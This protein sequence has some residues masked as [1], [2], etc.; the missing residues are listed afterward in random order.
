MGQ[1]FGAHI[2]RLRRRDKVCLVIGKEFE[3]RG[4]HR[5]IGQPRAQAIG[6]EPGQRHETIAPHRIAQHEGQRLKRNGDRIRR[7]LLFADDC[8]G[9]LRR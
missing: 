6:I 7:G 5:R 1:L 3:C 2:E 9:P 4:K 8:L